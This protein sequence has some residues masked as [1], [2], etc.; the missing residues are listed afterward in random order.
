MEIQI[1][2]LKHAVPDNVNNMIFKFVG[3]TYKTH[4]L[5]K[6]MDDY[7][8]YYESYAEDRPIHKCIDFVTKFKDYTSERFRCKCCGE[9]KRA[10]FGLRK[11][12]LL[13]RCTLEDLDNYERIS[14]WDD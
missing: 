5:A 7:T 1:L 14:C 8:F 9:Y 12:P 13:C 6:I 3:I 4:P 2:G 10:P 11:Q